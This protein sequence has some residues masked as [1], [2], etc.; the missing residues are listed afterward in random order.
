MLALKKYISNK[1]WKSKFKKAQ[2]LE[3]ALVMIFYYFVDGKMNK[4]II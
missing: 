4:V 1:M 2:D 3:Y